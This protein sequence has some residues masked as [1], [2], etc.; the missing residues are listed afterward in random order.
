M[1][2]LK[3]QINMKNSNKYFTKNKNSITSNNYIR[4][5]RI[6]K[7]RLPKITINT[8]ISPLKKKLTISLVCRS[9][10]SF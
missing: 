2:K 8:N 1:T 6:D 7:V 10:T 9:C 5:V 4:A 3:K